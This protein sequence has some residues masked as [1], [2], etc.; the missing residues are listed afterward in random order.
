[1]FCLC[2]FSEG[3]EGTLPIP[4]ICPHVSHPV[5]QWNP[6]STAAFDVPR[7]TYIGFSKI[8]LFLPL[9]PVPIRM[10]VY[11]RPRTVSL[12]RARTITSVSWVMICTLFPALEI[13]AA[14]NMIRVPASFFFFFLIVSLRFNISI[15]RLLTL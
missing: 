11:S 9:S 10:V 14:C 12:R 3:L 7:W 13:S 2:C 8:F 1:M 6:G 5:E 4:L 15:F